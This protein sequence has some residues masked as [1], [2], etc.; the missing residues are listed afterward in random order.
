VGLKHNRIKWDQVQKWY[1]REGLKTSWKPWGLPEIVDPQGSAFADVDPMPKWKVPEKIAISATMNGAFFTRHANPN[2]PIA[3][4]DIIRSAE[5]CIEAGAR[6]IHLHVRDGK[7]YNALDTDLFRR[8]IEPLRG[9]HPDIAIDGCL[10][11]VSD[12]ES[13]EMEVMLKAGLLDAVP[14][15]TCAILIGDNMFLK[16]PHA[17]I[18]KAQ[19]ALEA[20]VTPQI[21]VYNDAD[22]DNAR[23][24]LID[25]GL[26]D[27]PFFWII[28]PALPGCGP[29]YSPE[30]MISGLTRYVGLIREI[31][32]E[33]II[34]VC[35]A[36]RASTYLTT[37]ATMMGLNIR[38]GME[39]TV[40]KW[41]HKDDRLTSNAEHFKLALTIAQSLGRDLMTAQEYLS[42]IGATP[43]SVLQARAEPLAQR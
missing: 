25:T 38:V 35:A 2:V 43:A 29:M 39:D 1:E 9:R 12:G 26:L 20:G 17:I 24:F 36:G 33:S 16:S 19:L 37:L 13:R 8:V 34:S 11:A 3:P 31:S 22:I 30:S 41:P 10:V 32:Q 6:I 40:Y 28:L 21:A 4:E 7:G 23:R 42:L 5:E 15:N 18:K 14:I 27:P